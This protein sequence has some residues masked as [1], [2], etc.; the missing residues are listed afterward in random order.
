MT[1]TCRNVSALFGFTCVN[2][3]IIIIIIVYYYKNRDKLQ[4][5]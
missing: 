1:T 3:I 5:K 2:E 4:S